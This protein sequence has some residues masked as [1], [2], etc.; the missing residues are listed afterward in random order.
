MDKIDS[1][2]G[3]GL[4]TG[5]IAGAALSWTAKS[6][7]TFKNSKKDTSDEDAAVLAGMTSGI[8]ILVVIFLIICIILS[9]IFLVAVYKMM[10][11]FKALH[12]IMT[13]IFGSFWFM[14]ALIYYCVANDYTLT[15]SGLSRNTAG[16]NRGVPARNARNYSL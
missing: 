3:T 1:T 5:G 11:S 8:F 15:L 12:T 13:L 4:M 16:N 7:S 9:I 6:V 10:P 2:L 14:P